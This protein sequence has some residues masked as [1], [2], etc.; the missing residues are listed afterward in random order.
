M[1]RL[2]Q[3]VTGRTTLRGRE[4]ERERETNKACC[5]LLDA[6]EFC[7]FSDSLAAVFLPLQAASFFGF[8]SHHKNT[9][10]VDDEKSWPPILSA[11][12]KDQ[13]PRVGKEQR[14]G[15]LTQPS[16]ENDS[17]DL[18]GRDTRGRGVFLVFFFCFGFVFFLITCRFLLPTTSL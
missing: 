1:C 16:L 6:A 2:T 10:S 8:S 9:R 7:R 11:T 18:K 5:Y 3:T 14:V 15:F 12:D 17:N 13:S 4:G